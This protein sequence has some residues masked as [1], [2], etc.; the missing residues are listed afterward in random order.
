[1]LIDVVLHAPHLSTAALLLFA[2]MTVRGVT[3]LNRPRRAWRRFTPGDVSRGHPSGR[4]GR[5]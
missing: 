2:L 4:G 1:M 3:D 5:W